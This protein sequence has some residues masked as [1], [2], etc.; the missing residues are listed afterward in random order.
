MTTTATDRPVKISV[1]LKPKTIAKPFIWLARKGWLTWILLLI[2]W[3]IGSL[4][5]QPEYLPG[6]GQT[7]SGAKELVLNGTLAKYV[8]ISL[9]RI[10][11]GW[12]LGLLVAIPIGLIAGQ[13]T[14]F[15]WIIDP[16]INFFRF[17][18]AIAFLTLFLIWF[19][20]GEGSKVV[21]IFYA[22]L[23]PVVVNTL[24]GVLSIDPI[25]IQAARSQGA[26]QFQVFW[27]VTIPA[28]V[29]H[30][31]TGIRLGL[32]SAI[33][34][35][36]AAEM[37]AAQEGVG[38]L[39]YTSRLYFRTDWIFVGIVVL[40]LIGFFSDRLLRLLGSTV[41]ARFGTDTNS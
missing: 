18:P 34:S 29:P 3:W 7:L 9:R 26:S 4:L 15:R 10:F 39:I 27:S 16:L 38:Y 36:V 22:T 2:V 30:M 11:S 37:L 13:F 5:S 14:F 31:F 32:S 6:P 24:A 20:V 23:F 12:F 41:L 1:A 33:I 28:S 17:V 21:L 40:G 25:K 8:G 35:I 19:G